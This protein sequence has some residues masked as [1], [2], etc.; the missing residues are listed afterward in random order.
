MASVSGR[1]RRMTALMTAVALVV[2]AD[3]LVL[4]TASAR[5]AGRSLIVGRVTSPGRTAVPIPRRLPR[6]V[7]G[8]T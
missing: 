6:V 5:P 7:G 3:V 1:G 8:I 2:T 4:P